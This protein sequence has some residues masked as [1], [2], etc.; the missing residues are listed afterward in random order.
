[1]AKHE[2]V[3]IWIRIAA[4]IILIPGVCLVVTGPAWS[5]IGFFPVFIVALCALFQI[6]P[7]R[8]R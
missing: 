1:M 8:K 5:Q 4:L 3:R 6:N 7:W 2:D